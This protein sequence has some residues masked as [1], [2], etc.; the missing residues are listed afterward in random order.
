MN[1]KIVGMVISVIA[2]ALI[3]FAVVFALRQNAPESDTSNDGTSD[4]QYNENTTP[5]ENQGTDTGTGSSD[6]EV[7]S[8]EAKVEIKDMAF[9]AST[10]TVKRGTVVVWTNRDDVA[11]NVVT[12]GSAAGPNSET[13][14]KNQVYS[15]T[16]NETGTFNYICSFHS[17]MKGTVKVV[18]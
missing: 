2:V 15:Y 14:T 9:Q 18:D 1:K 3:A 13:L 16:F 7:Q 11:H 12:E 17:G 10:I 4:S 6:A 5:S 8:T